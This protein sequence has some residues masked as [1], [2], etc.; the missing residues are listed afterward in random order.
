MEPRPRLSTTQAASKEI[1]ASSQSRNE[2]PK[3]SLEIDVSNIVRHMR[4]LLQ[5][6]GPSQDHEL[7][8]AVSPLHADLVLQMHGRMRGLVNRSSTFVLINEDRCSSVYYEHLDG[9]VEDGLRSRIK[10]EA[11]T[12]P[13]STASNDDQ[14][15]AVCAGEPHRECAAISSSRPANESTI[16]GEH[17]ERED[18]ALKDIDTQVTSLPRSQLVREGEPRSDVNSQREECC[19]SGIAEAESTKQYYDLGVVQLQ[20]QETL[21]S[22]AY[23]VA[24][25][26]AKV[27][28]LP[29]APQTRITTE[30]TG[31]REESHHEKRGAYRPK[32]DSR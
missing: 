29:P 16:E 27:H 30:C 18:H 19:V 17:Q 32:S 25:Q 4:Q 7:L 20:K 13:S 10:N 3:D 2:G 1:I 15:A 28:R 22:S 31:T 9:D 6:K 26:R 24:R 12:S 8:E 21:K 11:I 5:N 23:E 14:D